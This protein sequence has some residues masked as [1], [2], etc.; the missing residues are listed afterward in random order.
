[1]IALEE[2]NWIHQ[3]NVTFD[4]YVMLGLPEEF[5]SD[6]VND[7][8]EGIVSPTMFGVQ[9]LDPPPDDT[10]VTNNPR[11]VGQIRAGTPI[12]SVVGM[13]GGPIFGFSFGE[14][15]RYWVVALQST[16]IRSS[17][18]VYGCSLPVL[19]SLMTEWSSGDAQAT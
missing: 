9:R 3:A 18:I 1:V 13:S 8:G 10:P 19:A 16:W 6:T 12:K 2:K 17:R 14:Q 7:A 4:G 11:F 15:T 5:S